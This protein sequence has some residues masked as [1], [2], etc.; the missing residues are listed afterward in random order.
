[1]KVAFVTDMHFGYRRFD[2]DAYAQGRE[3]ILSAARGADLL[4]LGGDNFDAPIPRMETLAEA[5]GILREALAIFHSRGISGTPI[6]AIHGNH[7]RR[8]KGFVHPTELL[9]QGGFLVNIHNKTEVWGSGGEKIAVSGMGNVPEDLAKNAVS[10]MGCRP[11]PG[12]FN[13]LVVHQNFAEFGFARGE[14][15]SFED[16]PDGFD[17]YL[18][19]HVHKTNLNGKVLN[20]GSTVVTQLRE[21]EIG[22]R[23]WLLYD[24]NAGKGEFVPVESR[25]LFRPVLEFENA[26][27][28]EVVGRVDGEVKRV[29]ASCPGRAPFVKVVVKGT[30]A[31][32]IG[33]PDLRFPNFG[34]NVSVE[35]CMDSGNLKERI[36]QIKIAREK[37][38]SPREWGMEI[39]RRKLDGT[40]Y[41]LGDADLVF[42]S[43]I[44][45]TFLANVKEKI[46]K[47]EE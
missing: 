28:D 26:A 43:L 21:D 30:L 40:P 44:Q 8:A 25:Q 41:G 24:T 18:C 45:G 12:A 39:L 36:A 29:L 42:E 33:S 15:L 11:V 35:N 19:G 10:Q 14:C 16:L 9:A 34:D 2:S 37:K 6:F 38:Q 5:M 7:D 27:P 3:A 17:L 13:V 47:G 31:K 32:G 4:I 23:G 20:P 22:P 1:M 46:E